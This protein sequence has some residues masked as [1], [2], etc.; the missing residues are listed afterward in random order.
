MVSSGRVLDACPR[1]W[2]ASLVTAGCEARVEAQGLVFHL[3]VTGERKTGR[4]NMV[5][6]RMPRQLQ[7]RIGGSSA[8]EQVRRWEAAVVAGDTQSA[9]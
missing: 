6:L 5:N 3:P 1:A 8:G 7:L 2:H 4:A 9:T